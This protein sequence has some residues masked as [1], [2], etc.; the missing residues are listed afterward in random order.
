[1]PKGNEQVSSSYH[2]LPIRSAKTWVWRH[3]SQRRPISWLLDQIRVAFQTSRHDAHNFKDVR[4]LEGLGPQPYDGRCQLSELG[5]VG[6][7]KID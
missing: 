6:G 4:P 7:R 3:P 2:T 5:A 1:M